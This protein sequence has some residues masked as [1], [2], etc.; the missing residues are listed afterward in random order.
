LNAFKGNAQKGRDRAYSIGA[1]S[2]LDSAKV[3]YPLYLGLT[4]LYASNQRRYRLEA[5]QST[6]CI[7]IVIHLIAITT[8]TTISHSITTVCSTARPQPYRALFTRV[9]ALGTT[10]ENNTPHPAH[11]IPQSN[12][13]HDIERSAAVDKVVLSHD[14]RNGCCERTTAFALVINHNVDKATDAKYELAI[15]APGLIRR[16]VPREVYTPLAIPLTIQAQPTRLCRQHQ[17]Q[18]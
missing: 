13:D 3:I 2:R 10:F 16:S 14:D 7:T 18:P 11:R 4:V 6:A 17:R 15:P 9:T 8:T 5:Q 12:T 1:R